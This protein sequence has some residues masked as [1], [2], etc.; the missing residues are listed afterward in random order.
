MNAVRS[1]YSNATFKGEG[2]YDLPAV[3]AELDNG[4]RVIETCWKL[5][6]EEAAVVEKTG[7]IYVQLVRFLPPMNV[8]VISMM[9]TVGNGLH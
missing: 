7:C 9:E 6:P 5:S 2:C 3:V 8:E 4:E 1:E